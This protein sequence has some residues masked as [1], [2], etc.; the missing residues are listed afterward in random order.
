MR[1]GGMGKAKQGMRMTEQEQGMG[2]AEQGI[3]G[4]PCSLNK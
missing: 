2:M 4:Y 1:G 3:A